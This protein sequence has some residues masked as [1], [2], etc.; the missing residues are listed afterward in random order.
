ML[1][2]L[3]IYYMHP[4][5]L[6][7]IHKRFSEV[8]LGLFKKHGIKVCDFYTDA[9]GADKIYYV[10]AFADRAARDAAFGAFSADPEWKA[11]YAA[12]HEDGGPIVERVEN[13]FMNRVDYI[14]PE[15]E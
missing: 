4:G 13:F 15:W 6:S 7:A 14:T 1:Y 12:S 5:R 3:R 10:C 2:E 9:D 11:A 8:T